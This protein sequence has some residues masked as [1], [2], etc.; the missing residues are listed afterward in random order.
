MH[1]FFSVLP[2]AQVY[3]VQARI[4][5][6]VELR[7]GIGWAVVLAQNLWVAFCTIDIFQERLC[8]AGCSFIV[9]Q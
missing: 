2:V 7:H 6:F 9:I 8:T 4:G 1:P 3:V 5:D